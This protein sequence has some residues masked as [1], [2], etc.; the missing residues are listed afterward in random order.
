LKFFGAPKC[1]ELLE[2]AESR[3]VSGFLMAGLLY[4]SVIVCLLIKPFDAFSRKNFG[5][6]IIYGNHLF[7]KF[8]GNGFPATVRVN[9]RSGVK[10][11]NA[12]WFNANQDDQRRATRDAS[13]VLAPNGT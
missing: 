3:D 8:C 11:S 4:Q 9:R 1:H 13:K 10:L 12:I 7:F 5:V 6:I 2:D